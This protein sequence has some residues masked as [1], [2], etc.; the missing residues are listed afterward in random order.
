MLG[1]ETSEKS[2]RQKG[3]RRWDEII[4]RKTIRRERSRWHTS[5]EGCRMVYSNHPVV[6][7]NKKKIRI[8]FDCTAKH[9]GV[10]LNDAA[11]QDPDLTNGLLGV[12]LRF[13][14]YPVTVSADVEALFHQVKVA[15][16]EQDMLRFLWWPAGDS[17]AEPETYRMS[18]HLFGGTWSP[19]V[20]SYALQQT[21]KD[22]REDFHPD[23]VNTV[24]KDFYVDDCLASFE[25][26]ESAIRLVSDLPVRLGRGVF[27]LCKWVSNRKAV[28]QAVPESERAEGLRDLNMQALP[29]ERTLG[30]LWDVETDA[31]TY[32]MKQPRRPMTR[33]GILGAVSSVFD[34]MGLVTPFTIRGK[35]LIQDLARE[36]SGWDEPLMSI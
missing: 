3:I 5:G 25:S 33:R 29:V 22:R 27:R 21:A 2:S 1:K 13:R 11:L 30:A 28:L 36:K 14:L 32:L 17:R 7:E 23:V 15:K 12:L 35:M 10:W 4:N 9:D 16:R 6:S 34:P 24:L 18:V 20:C 26:E 8:V 31:F 19:S